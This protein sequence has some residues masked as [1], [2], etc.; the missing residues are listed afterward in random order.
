MNR[1]TKPE[2]HDCAVMVRYTADVTATTYHEVGEFVM[3]D[4]PPR[5]TFEMT[6][7]RKGDSDW[8]DRTLCPFFSTTKPVASL[9]VALLVDSLLFDRQSKA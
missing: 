9:V 2:P 1:P 3:P 7:T 8:T 5:R 4:Q 6:L